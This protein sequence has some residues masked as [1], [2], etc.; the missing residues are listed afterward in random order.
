MFIQ[1]LNWAAIGP[2]AL[3]VLLWS[4]GA[5]F[6]KWG[7]E[8]ASAFA[9]LLLRFV[10]ACAALGLLALTRRRWLPARGTRKQVALVGVLLTGGYTIFYLLS[11]DA[12]LTPGVLAT[13]LGVQPILTLMLVERR[14]NLLRVLGLLLA[15]GGLTLVV[16]D[17][18]LAARFS[19]LGIGLSLAALLCITLGS[20]FQ[21]GIQQSPMDVLPLQY[22]IGLLMCAVVVP[23]QPFEVE[24]SV[25]QWLG[26]PA[27]SLPPSYERR[28][29][30][31]EGVEG[32][33]GKRG[34]RRRKRTI[35]GKKKE[36]P[37]DF[38]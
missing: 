21:K 5:I 1:R 23:F 35:Y 3:F 24:G 30:K 4:A 28:G 38:R 37:T 18:L 20:I 15:L 11:L 7:L 9:F 34:T 17:S 10:L 26:A 32:G 33:G 25:G 14:A 31:G 19:L 8:H 12:G 22:A 2:T 13:V 6:S 36:T 29:E 27:L 16:L